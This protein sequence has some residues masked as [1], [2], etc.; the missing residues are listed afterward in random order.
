V[1]GGQIVLTQSEKEE[2]PVEEAVEQSRAWNE[3]F[4]G[5]TPV[6][7]YGGLEVRTEKGTFLILPGSELGPVRNGRGYRFQW[8]NKTELRVMGPRP[9]APWNAPNG[10]V[11]FT[12]RGNQPMDPTTGRTLSRSEA[13]FKILP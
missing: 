10:Y 4:G 9:E 7:P 3:I 11:V 6:I 5:K 13:H 2:D 8:S 1:S 12:N